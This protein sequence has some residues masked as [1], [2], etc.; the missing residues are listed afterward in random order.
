MFHE[1]SHSKISNNINIKE[2]TTKKFLVTKLLYQSLAKNAQR[3]SFLYDGGKPFSTQNNINSRTQDGFLG[4]SLCF[5]LLNKDT[6]TLFL[7]RMKVILKLFFNS[8]FQYLFM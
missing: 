3:S 1:F 4:A 2:N 8:S 6:T 5:T 7:F